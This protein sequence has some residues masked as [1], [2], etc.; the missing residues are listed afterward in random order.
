MSLEHAILG[1]LNDRPYSGYDLKKVFNASVRHFWPADQSQ[2]YRTL[3]RMTEKGWTE[4]EVVRQ[5]SRPDRKQYHITPTGKGELLRWLTTPLPPEAQRSAEMIQVFFAGELSDE[6]A[7]EMFER[8]ADMM[9]V[10]LAQYQQIPREIEA[11]SQ[12]TNSPRDFFFWK[13]TI[14]V[15]VHTLQSNLN[16]IENLIQRI[17]NGELPRN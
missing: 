15:G 2:I 5:E 11:Y 1:F 14:D 13:L 10:G 16:F 7:I 12:Y 3:S 8:A 9:R 4:I 17:H 6:E